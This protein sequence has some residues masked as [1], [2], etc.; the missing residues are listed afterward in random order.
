[1]ALRAAERKNINTVMEVVIVGEFD[2]SE[3]TFDG[4]GFYVRRCAEKHFLE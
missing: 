1:M 2:W 4:D 3:S